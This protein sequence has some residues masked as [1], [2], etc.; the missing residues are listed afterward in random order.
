MFIFVEVVQV[1]AKV[2]ATQTH[3]DTNTYSG[4]DIHILNRSKE[5]FFFKFTITNHHSLQQM[6]FCA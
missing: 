6:H 1:L 5:F 2:F 3:T 4:V